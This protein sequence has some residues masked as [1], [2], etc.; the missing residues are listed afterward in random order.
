LDRQNPQTLALRPLLNVRAGDVIWIAGSTQDPE[1]EVVLDIFQR[2]RAEHPALRLFIVPRQRE[3]FEE[4]A[5]VLQRSGL[6]FLRRSE[7]NG[8]LRDTSAVVLVDTIG[9]LGAL[10]GLADVAFVGGSLDAKRGGQNMIEPAA[11]GAAVVF[12]PHVWNFRDTAHRLVECE[13]AIQIADARMLEAVVKRLFSDP[14]ERQRLGADA[15]QFVR[16]QQGATERTMACLDRLLG[17][18]H[19]Q[20]TALKQPA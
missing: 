12:G 14:A 18:R 20:E 7:L 10:W 3:R 19:Q 15:Q 17:T 5:G 16:S 6:L 9:E 1:E 13:G 8:P 4:V 11:Y 2:V